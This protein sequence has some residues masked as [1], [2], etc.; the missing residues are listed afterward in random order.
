[1]YAIRSY[2]VLIM[3]R[4]LDP[5]SE[6]DVSRWWWYLKMD[7]IIAAAEITGVDAIHPGYGFL[8]ENARFA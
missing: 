4:R 2:Y 8:S 6:A 5:C 3:R 7:R 1:M